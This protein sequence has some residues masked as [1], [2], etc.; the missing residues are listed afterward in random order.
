MVSFHRRG[1]SPWHLPT[2]HLVT[3]HRPDA[4]ASAGRSPAAL[5]PAPAI[6]TLHEPSA[7]SLWLDAQRV[8]VA[9][10]PAVRD[11]MQYPDPN[12][13]GLRLLHGRLLA[14]GAQ[15]ALDVAVQTALAGQ[16]TALAL[17]FAPG[18]WP[19]TLLIRP[20]T[21][22]EA[23]A[24]RV[25]VVVHDPASM[26]LCPQA[27]QSLFRL[28]PSEARVTQLL[29]AGLDVSTI[30][31]VLRVQRNTVQSHVKQV[32]VKTGTGRQAAL[33]ALVLRSAARRCSPPAAGTVASPPQA[34]A[35]ASTPTLAPATHLRAVDLG[36]R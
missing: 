26:D 30:A 27:L 17:P 24:A 5:A 6:L 31:G 15:A 32:L 4:A 21:L 7:W 14:L 1:L 20:G 25:Q 10:G 29:A 22:A 28:T 35:K 11:W 9:Q 19:V 23:D 2:M 8:C 34:T 13:A 33:V 18:S 16:G 3:G 36:S 12:T